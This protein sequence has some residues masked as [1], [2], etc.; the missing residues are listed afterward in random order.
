MQS[1][2]IVRL[3]DNEVVAYLSISAGNIYT[4]APW[5][6]DGGWDDIWEA[7]PGDHVEHVA[8]WV[9]QRCGAAFGAEVC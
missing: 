5:E 2:R 1:I 3:A 9:R 8:A 4:V 7:R 6:G